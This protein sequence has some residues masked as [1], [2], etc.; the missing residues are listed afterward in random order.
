MG[1]HTDDIRI[2]MGFRGRK[3]E[4]NLRGSK[5]NARRRGGDKI[6][7]NCFLYVFVLIYM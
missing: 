2:I 3:R 6:F 4:E 7:K 5:F 1:G